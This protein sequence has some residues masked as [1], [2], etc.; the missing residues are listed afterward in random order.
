MVLPLSLHLR[1]S[2]AFPKSSLRCNR[3]PVIE[4]GIIG[5]QY[6]FA[7]NIWEFQA[8][9]SGFDS[10]HSAFCITPDLGGALMADDSND[11]LRELCKQAS[12]ERDLQKLLEL[13]AEID[14]LLGKLEKK[15]GKTKPAHD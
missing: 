9:L 13:A 15:P 4:I 10:I 6:R 3:E 12:V 5:E 7:N 1:C 14:S 2:H 8:Y 11:H